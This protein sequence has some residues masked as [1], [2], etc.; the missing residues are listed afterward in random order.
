MF[1]LTMVNALFTHLY[2]RC[3]DWPGIAVHCLRTTH[4]NHTRYQD[5]FLRIR[6]LIYI[7]FCDKTRVQLFYFL[8][9]IHQEVAWVPRIISIGTCI[10]TAFPRCDSMKISW[11]TLKMIQIPS[12]LPEPWGLWLIDRRSFENF[13]TPFR[14]RVGWC[15]SIWRAFIRRKRRT[16]T[17]V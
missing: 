12:H 4:F 3:I 9:I 14:Y 16:P 7:L 2:Q 15:V 11:F 8:N 13:V 17:L 5:N 10:F 6:T 1:L